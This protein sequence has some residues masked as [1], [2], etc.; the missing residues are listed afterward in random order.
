MVIWTDGH[1]IIVP[2]FRETVA[3][4]Y[5]LELAKY[6]GLPVIAWNADNSALEKAK[7]MVGGN[8][9]RVFSNKTLFP[10]PKQCPAPAGPDPQAPG[11]GHPGPLT[12]VGDDKTEILSLRLFLGIPS[13]GRVKCSYIEKENIPTVWTVSMIF[14]ITGVFHF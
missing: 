8:I 2:L 14:V 11:A 9:P 7:D 13:E 6:V 12:K 4:Q 1:P 5:F 10:E 3:S